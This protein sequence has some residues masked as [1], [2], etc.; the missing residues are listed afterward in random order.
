[1]KFKLYQ[2]NQKVNQT[3]ILLWKYLV[4][5]WR[6][7]LDTT[8]STH[9]PTQIQT[10]ESSRFYRFP[11][12]TYAQVTRLLQGYIEN[13]VDMNADG[14]CRDNCAYY[15]LA[16]RHGCFKEQFCA[17]Q[18]VCNGRIIDCQYIDS[19]MWVCPAVSFMDV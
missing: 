6:L 14:T 12:E 18:P 7:I 10:E 5:F 19:D 2:L 8:P 11:G 16:T 13:E 15:T 17:K 3:M 1:M 4:N 9:K